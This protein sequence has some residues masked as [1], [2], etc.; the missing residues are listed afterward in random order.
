MT[1]LASHV[2]SHLL[3]T[4]FFTVLRSHGCAALR[5]PSQDAETFESKMISCEVLD[6]FEYVNFKNYK[7]S[8]HDFSMEKLYGRKQHLHDSTWAPA[9]WSAKN[10][11]E[12]WI[13]QMKWTAADALKPAWT[14]ASFKKD[15]LD[16]MSRHKNKKR[17]SRCLKQRTERSAREINAPSIKG[18]LY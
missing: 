16:D 11:K 6:L 10:S 8:I 17:D 9:D 5:L 3:L 1:S 4:V 14:P 7:R 13:P 15:M 12:D 18:F 2:A